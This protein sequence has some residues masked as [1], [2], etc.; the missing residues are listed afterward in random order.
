MDNIELLI[1]LKLWKDFIIPLFLFVIF[2]SI[3]I[4]L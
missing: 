4:I 1:Q 3:S 2:I